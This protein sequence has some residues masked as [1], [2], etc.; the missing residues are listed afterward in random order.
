MKSSNSCPYVSASILPSTAPSLNI[1]R[2]SGL[3]QLHVCRLRLKTLSKL[4]GLSFQPVVTEDTSS[5]RPAIS[6]T[7]PGLDSV[8]ILVCDTPNVPRL[9]TQDRRNG[10]NGRGSR[11]PGASGVAGEGSGKDWKALSARRPSP[12]KSTS[13]C[14][15]A[16][17]PGLRLTSKGFMPWTIGLLK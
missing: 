12:T 15:G 8:G 13:L 1:G 14:A 9:R 5:Y 10:A 11:A 2:I 16:S 17:V 6:A 3:P 4:T 7:C